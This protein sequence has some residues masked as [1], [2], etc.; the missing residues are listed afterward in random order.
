MYV[1]EHYEA[2]SDDAVKSLI[3]THPFGSLVT[4]D[5]Q[6]SHIPFLLAERAGQAVLVGHVARA[7]PHW[8]VF[9]GQSSALAL[10]Q[11]P[12]GYISPAWG[13]CERLV[14]TWNYIVAQVRGVPT[15]VDGA[16]ARDLLNEMTVAQESQRSQP[17]QPWE[18]DELD[19]DL[20]ERLLT[21]LVVFEMPVVEMRGKWKLSQNRSD[22]ERA[23]FISG[24][25]AEGNVVLAS[26][27]KEKMK[28]S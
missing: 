13:D 4:S 12:Q 5:L 23:G 28:N 16:H 8:R 18:M 22:S 25:E 14:P 1:P 10:F 11:G 24:L 2:P 21:A 26:S 6:A 17:C 15:L 7:N 19:P 27:M 3:R 20:L 9:D